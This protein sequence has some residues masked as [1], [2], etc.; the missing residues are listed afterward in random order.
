MKMALGIGSIW[1]LQS[2]LCKLEIRGIVCGVYS[3]CE[4]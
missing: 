4:T 1:L 3:C 2:D